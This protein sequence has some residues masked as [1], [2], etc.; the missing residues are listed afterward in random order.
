MHIHQHQLW[1][2]VIIQAQGIRAGGTGTHDSVAEIVQE[3]GHVA[4]DETFVLDDQDAESVKTGHLELVKTKLTLN[5]RNCYRKQQICLC[6]VKLR[7]AVDHSHRASA[8]ETIL[9]DRSRWKGSAPTLANGGETGQV[10]SFPV[11]P[12]S[13]A[14][15]LERSDHPTAKEQAQHSDDGDGSID[16]QADLPF[17]KDPKNDAYHAARQGCPERPAQKRD[18][19]KEHQN[20]ADKSDE[21]G[22]KLA[23]RFHTKPKRR[24]SP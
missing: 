15:P 17:R 19:A 13:F 21:D 12:S 11:D 23:D 4:A 1:S 5:I 7:I 8:Q 14:L 20:S 10:V 22:E 3:R 2:Q 18:D 9:P 16:N 6:F 24:L